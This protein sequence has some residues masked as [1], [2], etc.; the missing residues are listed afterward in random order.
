MAAVLSGNFDRVLDAMAPDEQADATNNPAKNR[1]AFEKV[2]R[3]EFPSL[4]ESR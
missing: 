2:F 3:E 4:R 1:Q